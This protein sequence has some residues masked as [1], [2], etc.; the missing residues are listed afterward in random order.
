VSLLKNICTKRSH[1]L[2]SIMSSTSSST[3]IP[4]SVPTSSGV[5]MPSYQLV[6]GVARI[7]RHPLTGPRTGSRNEPNTHPSSHLPRSTYMAQQPRKTHD[8]DTTLFLHLALVTSYT[9]RITTPKQPKLCKVHFSAFPTSY[10]L[11]LSLQPSSHQNKLI[12]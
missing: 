7:S 11:G 6:P 1:R 5:L 3:P 2:F 9:S 4:G 8:L 10:V 12:R